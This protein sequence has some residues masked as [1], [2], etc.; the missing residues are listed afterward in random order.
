MLLGFGVL[1]GGCGAVLGRRRVVGACAGALLGLCLGP[2]GLVITA[3][4]PKRAPPQSP[5]STGA[6]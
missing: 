2:M 4:T 3:V 1:F 5:P 6:A